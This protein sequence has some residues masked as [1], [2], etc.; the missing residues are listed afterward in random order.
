[1]RQLVRE[2]VA[3]EM[4]GRKPT[5]DSNNPLRVRVAERVLTAGDLEGVP[6]HATVVVDP[7]TLVSP[8][9]HDVMAA[10]GLRLRVAGCER[11]PTVALAA[12]GPGIGRRAA[13]AGLLVGRGHETQEL[14]AVPPVVTDEVEAGRR[15]A[16]AVAAAHQ[17][18]GIVLAEDGAGAVIAGN[19]T[20]GARA[21]LGACPAGA[22]AARRAYGVNLLVVPAGLLPEASVVEVVAAWLDAPPPPD[23]SVANGPL[24]RIQELERRHGRT[25]GER[26]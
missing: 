21:A 24:W 22:A 18:L 11:P 19:K 15:V 23:V 26:G 17:E 6:D 13:V 10:R 16:A 9:V 3:E 7:G 12:V 20:P 8:L 1:M 14:G 4:A 25:G 2:L 5:G